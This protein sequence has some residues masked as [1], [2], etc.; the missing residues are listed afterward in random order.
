LD[1]SS[2]YDVFLNWDGAD[3]GLSAN[4]WGGDQARGANKLTTQDGVLVQFGDA[5]Y[6]YLGCIRTDAAKK[7]SV[8]STSSSAG[9][10]EVRI[11]NF[12]NR[13]RDKFYGKTSTGDTVWTHDTPI[14]TN[15]Q[16][17]TFLINF[18]TDDDL[19]VGI[20][21]ELAEMTMEW[22]FM[23]SDTVGLSNPLVEYRWTE[24][25][26]TSTVDDTPANVQP[27]Y[28]ATVA[29]DLWGHA[30]LEPTKIGFSGWQSW[31]PLREVT[32]AHTGVLTLT[33]RQDHNQ[34]VLIKEW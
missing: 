23:V 25:V 2:T 14:T 28:L 6:R 15:D 31:Q 7:L 34:N 11:S 12:Y 5:A 20:D 29:C 1:A 33:S 13:Y 3:L 17:A 30:H 27:L 21:K 22:N 16:S 9:N 10:I 4:K 24:L 18:L 32:V 26:S 8:Y 19:T